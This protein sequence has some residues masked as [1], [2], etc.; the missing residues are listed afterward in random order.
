MT[1]NDLEHAFTRY[2][3]PYSRMTPDGKK[4]DAEGTARKLLDKKASNKPVGSLRIWL[5]QRADKRFVCWHQQEQKVVLIAE[6]L[7]PCLND[8]NLLRSG[9]VDATECT[10]L[11]YVLGAD[12]HK[13]I[14]LT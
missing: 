14:D 11:E 13:S 1:L 12:L 5:G 4:V 8:P 6:F 2:A 9:S 10:G 7:M 3:V